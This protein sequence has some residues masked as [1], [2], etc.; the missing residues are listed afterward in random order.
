MIQDILWDP[1]IE[2]GV[3]QIDDE[4]RVLVLA[5]NETLASFRSGASR[6]QLLHALGA[7]IRETKEHFESEEKVMDENSYPHLQMHS[8][9]HNDLLNKLN[10]LAIAIS[11]GRQELDEMVLGFVKDWLVNHMIGADGLFGEYVA[12]NV[13]R[14]SNAILT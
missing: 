14:E 7:I 5:F 6:V 9:E 12:D 13:I 8:K 2:T 3:T 4:H 1:K 11:D 10:I